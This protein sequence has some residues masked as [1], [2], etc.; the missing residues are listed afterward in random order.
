MGNRILKMGICYN[1][2]IAALSPY[3]EILFYR[4]I[5]GCDDFGRYSADVHM[6]KGQLFCLCPYFGAEEI[7]AALGELEAV[8]LIAF[9]T[10]KGKRY[11]YLCGWEEHQKLRY[12]RAQFPAPPAQTECEAKESDAHACINNN[13]ISINEVEEKRR[14]AEVKAEA[15]VEAEVEV[16]EVEEKRTEEKI[17][18]NPP[19]IPP[20]G[21]GEG[22]SAESD[23][24]RFWEAYPRKECRVRARNVFLKLAPRRPLL[25]KILSAITR[26]KAT[27]QW[28]REGGR[29]VPY[30]SRWLLEERWEETPACCGAATSCGSFDTD[31]F[32]AAAVGSAWR[33]VCA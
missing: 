33:E 1:E 9:Y 10:V 7:E 12:R 18:Y 26:F 28:N 27:D 8:G 20:R 6:I 24:E 13:I 25:E 5:V 4:L 15:E 19:Y 17:E 3:G 30:P 21:T 23:F 16:E 31:D 11:L 22:T 29:Y 32:F 14:E 2:R